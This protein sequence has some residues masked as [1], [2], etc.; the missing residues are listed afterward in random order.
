MKKIHIIQLAINYPAVNKS[1]STKNTEE[2]N[3]SFL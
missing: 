2:A 3:A 1:L